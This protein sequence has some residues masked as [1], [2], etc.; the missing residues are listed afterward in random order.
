MGS[1]FE[2]PTLNPTPWKSL[3][4]ETGLEI[5]WPLFPPASLVCQFK[6]CRYAVSALLLFR[7]GQKFA[8]FRTLF[9]IPYGQ[10]F[11]LFRPVSFIG[12]PTRAPLWLL[13]KAHA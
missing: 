12:I 6:E 8:L 2:G 1:H 9:I 10:A 3:R 13:L 7:T 5:G 11:T 4:V